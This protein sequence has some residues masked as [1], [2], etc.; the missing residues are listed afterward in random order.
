MRDLIRQKIIDSISSPIQA[1]TRRDIR[2]PG[3]LGKAIAVIGMRR[4]G[5]TTFLHQVM[6]DRLASGSVRQSLLYFSFED[7]RLAGMTASDLSIVLEEYYKLFPELRDREKTLFLF[8]EIQN[9]PGWE[10]FTRRVL[11]SEKAD[12]FLSGSSAKLLSREVAT[13]MRGRAM[14]ATVYPFS[15]RETLRH[16]GHEP[17]QPIDTLGKAE[18]S[19]LEKRF[20]GY[21]GI[22]GFPEGLA[23]SIQDRHSLLAGYVDVVLLRDVIERYEVSHPLALRRLVR[24]LLS[25][26]AGFLSIHKFYGDLRSQGVAVSKDSLHAFLGYLEDAFLI[27]TVPLATD[28]ER[29][30]MVNLRKV[31]PIDPGLIP[32]FDV[33]GKANT[34]HGFETCVLLEL[35][36]RGAEVFYVRGRSG[37]EVDFLARYPGGRRE[38]IQVCASL[39]NPSV[40]EREIG[41]LLSAAVEYPDAELLLVT[42]N[43]ETQKKMPRNIRMIP[44]VSWFLSENPHREI[45]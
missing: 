23:V 10:A 41:G 2:V 45:S 34:G 13:A 43:Q 28:S 7:E 1:F 15:F 18:R 27:R 4:T 32:V 22:G 8:D 9:I 42:L 17:S 25:N 37:G 38:L 36:R 20:L 19:D 39:E 12:L 14:E 16:S 35:D 11:D 6:T 30:R 5:K 24:H 29:R 21:L 31:Y 44:A 40:V 33:S 26:A 3:I